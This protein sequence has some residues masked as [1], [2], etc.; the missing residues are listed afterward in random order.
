MREEVLRLER[1][2]CRVGGALQLEDFSLTLFAGE[3]VGLLPVKGHGLSALVELLRRNLPL[4]EGYVYY[5]EELLNSWRSPRPQYNRVGVIQSQ[6]SLVEGLTVADNIFVLRPGFK[7]WLLRPGLLR[8]QLQPFLDE[9][10][11][12]LSADSYVEELTTFQRC[13]VELVKAVVAGSRLVILRDVST[14]ISESELQRLHAILRRYAAQGVAFLYIGFHM[15]ELDQICDRTAFF[16]NGRVTKVLCP[17]ESM[18]H[19]TDFY[20][21]RAWEAQLN[22]R[23]L[24]GEKPAVLRVEGLAGGLVEDLSFRVSPGECIVLQDLENHIFG[25]LLGLFLGD[26]EPRRGTIE[27]DGRP[28]QPGPTRDMAVILEQPADSML[29][30]ELSC[31]DN[32]CFTIDHRLPELW[33][34]TRVRKGLRRTLE[35]ELRELDLDRSPDALSKRRRYDLVYHRIMLQNPKVV[36]CLQPFRGADLALRMHIWALLEALMIR[37]VAVVILAVNLADSLSVAGRLIRIRR[38]RP[39]EVYERADF[40][41]IP[42]IAP[43]RELYRAREEEELP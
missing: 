30:P 9:V 5:R 10:E 11:V 32:L 34:S 40:A 43:W 35:E 24:A 21:R 37:G 4:E 8:R 3:I 16:S 12:A 19:A 31:L 6:G 18:A 23:S 39:H 22:Q 29:F 1:V 7:K 20:D 26:L 14:F 36:F 33:R 15:E 17:A 28:F 25:D 2:A 27:L 38:G 13:V 41:K 42:F